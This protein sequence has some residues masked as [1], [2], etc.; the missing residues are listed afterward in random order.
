MNSTRSQY[1]PAVRWGKVENLEMDDV[2]SSE[3]VDDMNVALELGWVR[4]ILC[5]GTD[6]TKVIRQ[7]VSL[8]TLTISSP[9]SLLLLQFSCCQPSNVNLVAVTRTDC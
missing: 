4:S 2:G 6:E 7:F 3:I 1:L 5:T 8:S 9:S